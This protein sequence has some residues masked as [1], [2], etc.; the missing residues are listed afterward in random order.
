MKNL[1]HWP[2]LA[3]NSAKIKLAN[4]QCPHVQRKFDYERS[5]ADRVRE[6]K[7]L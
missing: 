2:G 3:A 4:D 5:K 6:D 7:V 1:C